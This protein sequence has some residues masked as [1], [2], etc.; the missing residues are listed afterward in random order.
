MNNTLEHRMEMLRN[1][2]E[3]SRQNSMSANSRYSDL[4]GST[5][6]E[7]KGIPAFSFFKIK[8]LVAVVLFAGF[9]ILD[10]ADV[11]FFSINADAIIKAITGF[12]EL[13][14]LR[15]LVEGFL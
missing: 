13:E 7:E 6:V 14:Q 11:N 2:R 10:A 3:M 9:L 8:I 12:S 1:A 4:K 15:S 5:N